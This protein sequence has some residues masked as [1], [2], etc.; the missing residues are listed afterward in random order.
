MRHRPADASRGPGGKTN[1]RGFAVHRTYQRASVAA[2]V[3][4]R[5]RMPV[6]VVATM[7]VATLCTIVLQAK[8]AKA[9]PPT[10][11]V[12]DYNMGNL[13]TN[14][15]ELSIAVDPNNPNRLMAG[16]NQRNGGQSWFASVD[17][18]RTFTNG[19]LPFG[20]LTAPGETAGN[21]TASDPSL[22]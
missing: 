2:N 17:G 18:G 9:A 13:A 8:P 15:R 14:E 3:R 20:T 16:S 19:A 21:T 4:A 22:A 6:A 5:S 7:L 12:H 10:P 11:L 1:M